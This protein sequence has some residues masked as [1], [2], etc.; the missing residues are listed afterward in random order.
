MLLCRYHSHVRFH[1]YFQIL[2]RRLLSRCKKFEG[3]VYSCRKYLANFFSSAL[4][5][6]M[7]DQARR[8]DDLGR[9]RR[10]R[11]RL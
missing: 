11:D 8:A 1:K 2:S 3:S 5:D 7:A 6:S 9:R 4:L 10:H